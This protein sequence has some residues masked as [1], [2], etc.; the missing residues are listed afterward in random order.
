MGICGHLVGYDSM[1][2][3]GRGGGQNFCQKNSKG[4]GMCARKAKTRFSNG[5]WDQ[6]GKEINSFA[7]GPE[8]DQFPPKCLLQ[9]THKQAS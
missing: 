5:N 2:P 6:S 4:K 1:A 8:G 3:R 7:L 9:L